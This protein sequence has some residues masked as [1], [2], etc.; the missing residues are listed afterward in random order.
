MCSRD[1]SRD[2]ADLDPRGYHR[3]S[4][5]SLPPRI[6]QQHTSYH[7]FAISLSLRRADARC[8]GERNAAFRPVRSC[9]KTAL[10]CVVCAL[11]LSYSA[12]AAPR[13]GSGIALFRFDRRSSRRECEFSRTCA[14]PVVGCYREWLTRADKLIICGI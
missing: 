10:T 3:S 8:R 6:S 12:R 2:I 13:S 9:S 7:G 1:L 14:Q 5:V 11:G 4:L